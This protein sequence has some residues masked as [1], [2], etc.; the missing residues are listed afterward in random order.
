MESEPPYFDM[1][2]GVTCTY[3]KFGLVGVLQLN[4]ARTKWGKQQGKE[5]TKQQNKQNKP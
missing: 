5:A 2:Q 4:G 3:A 1:S